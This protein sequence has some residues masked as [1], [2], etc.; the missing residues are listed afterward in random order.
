MKVKRP[1]IEDESSPS[2]IIISNFHAMG[3]TTNFGEHFGIM[4]SGS[5]IS[6]SNSS[7]LNY[8][9]GIQLTG[10]RNKVIDT[11]IK[12]ERNIDLD[13]EITGIKIGGANNWIENSEIDGYNPMNNNPAS[14]ISISNNEKQ[15]RLMSA[16]II[17][18]TLLGHLPFYFGTPANEKSFLEIYG[19]DAPLAQTETLPE[20]FI[21]KKMP[22]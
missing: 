12:M 10:D 4:I 14:D 15:K 3:S 6:I 9:F 7:L 19:Y 16:K 13:T 17:N 11:K 1:I 5:D 8:R 22:G 20:N 2:E 18:T 21:L